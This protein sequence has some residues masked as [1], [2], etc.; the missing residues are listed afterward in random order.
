MPGVE[1]SAGR[2]VLA[3]N[4]GMDLSGRLVTCEGGY[5]MPRIESKFGYRRT[6]IKNESVG[7]SG[8]DQDR[9]RTHSQPTDC[10][11]A[12]PMLNNLARRRWR[13][14]ICVLAV[15]GALVFSSKVF[16]AETR[17]VADSA[18]RRVEV[19]AKIERIFAAAAPAGVFIYTLAPEKLINWNLPL[20]AEQRAYMPARYAALPALGRLTGR[21]NTASVETVLAARPDVILDYGTI[22]PTYVSLAE[23]IQK[24]T[25]VP[26][27][28]F[29][30]A[31]DQ[32]AAVFKSA[33]TALAANER[34]R[35]LSRY[36]EHVACRSR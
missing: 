20:S 13:V 22:N 17:V 16:S 3:S 29:D 25:G 32:I 1:M 21:G 23:R 7:K 12:K 18:G 19:P 35:Q 31:F 2:F 9:M 8:L 33:G 36:T 14:D 34:A 15:L 5:S 26:Y 11:N 28:L 6:T 27:L 4:A 10:R 30:G 24:Q